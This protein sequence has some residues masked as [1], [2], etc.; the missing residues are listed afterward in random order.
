[1]FNSVATVEMSET[2]AHPLQSTLT[3]VSLAALGGQF[4]TAADLRPVVGF[5][6]GL[7]GN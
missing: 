4:E 5:D 1:M 7:W 2:L 6:L 3:I